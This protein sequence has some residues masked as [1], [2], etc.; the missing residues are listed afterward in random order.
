VD[1][2]RQSALLFRGLAVPRWETWSLFCL[3][4]GC[5]KLETRSVFPRWLSRGERG[6]PSSV[7]LCCH[8][9]PTRVRSRRS[10]GAP[11]SKDVGVFPRLPAPEPLTARWPSPAG[12]TLSPITLPP[13]PLPAVDRATSADN[14]PAPRILDFSTVWLPSYGLAIRRLE[15]YPVIRLALF[16]TQR[17]A[18]PLPENGSPGRMRDRPARSWAERQ[19]DLKARHA[20]DPKKQQEAA[21][22]ADE[23]KLPAQPPWPVCLPLLVQI[24]DS[25][26]RSLPHLPW[27][28]LCRMCSVHLNRSSAGHGTL[29]IRSGRKPSR[30]TA[31]AI[32]LSSTAKPTTP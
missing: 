3:M 19:A 25:C 15:R 20:S 26:S 8:A 28:P 11:D 16:T 29:R 2:I 31:P 1:Q 23:R 5:S 21:W 30:S 6:F 10:C 7:G 4:T 24:P 27:V 17:R 13:P 12:G 32:A 9:R 18:N 14:L 22:A